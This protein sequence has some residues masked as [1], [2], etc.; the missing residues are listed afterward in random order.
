MGKKRDSKPDVKAPEQD[1]PK[2]VDHVLTEE[3]MKNNPE[4]EAQG[5]K[6]GDLIQVPEV[7][8]KEPEQPAKKPEV[9]AEATA[10][11]E[12]MLARGAEKGD[13]ELARVGPY[14][15]MARADKAY[16]LDNVGRK[17]SPLDDVEKTRSLLENLSRH[18]PKSTVKVTR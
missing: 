18:L 3:D 12:V 8:E 17:I 1:E 7:E 9:V 6:V 15:L 16:I 5:L 10:E 2:F 11:E 4:L 13:K 14:I